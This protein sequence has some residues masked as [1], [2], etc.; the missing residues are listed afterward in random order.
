LLLPVGQDRHSPEHE[1][2]KSRAG[3][4]LKFAFRETGA[5]VSPVTMSHPSLKATAPPCLPLFIKVPLKEGWGILGGFLPLTF[6]LG[7]CLWLWFWLG[8]F[9][10]NFGFGLFGVGSFWKGKEL[11]KGKEFLK[12]NC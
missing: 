7:F 12:G 4:S 6:T 3:A 8:Y 1:T 11:L 5:Q 2:E 10:L 9:A